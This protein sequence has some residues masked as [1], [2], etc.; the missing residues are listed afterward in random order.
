MHLQTLTDD[1]GTGHTKQM[2]SWGGTVPVLV[3][4]MTWGKSESV[5]A[6]A[7]F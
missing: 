5:S 6:I 1:P 3:L 2:E 4:A 7:D